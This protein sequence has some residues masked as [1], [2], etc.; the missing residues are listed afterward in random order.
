MVEEE[1]VTTEE[2]VPKPPKQP[3]FRGFLYFWACFEIHA[4]GTL[5]TSVCKGKNAIVTNAREVF[6]K[7][8]HF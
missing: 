7:K 8:C 6:G 3:K 4:S 2:V 1:A 5:E